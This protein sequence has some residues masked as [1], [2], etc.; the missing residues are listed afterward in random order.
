MNTFEV[1]SGF[2]RCQDPCYSE[3][4]DRYQTRW[5]CE[6]GKWYARLDVYRGEI[7]KLYVFHRDFSQAWPCWSRLHN[8]CGVDS[9]QFGFFDDGKMPSEEIQ[10]H[11]ETN[12][13]FYRNICDLN[14]NNTAVT[15][16]FGAAS[17]TAYGDGSYPVFA[18]IDPTTK[19]AVAFM[20]DY[21][22]DSDE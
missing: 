21:L 15:I 8:G 19:K 10:Y 2:M 7:G 14:D 3:F 11:Y 13:G 22:G 12:S 18:V 9:G 17:S 20:V 1:T 5:P 4:N 6:N 16:E